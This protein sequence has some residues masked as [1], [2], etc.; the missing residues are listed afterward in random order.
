MQLLFLVNKLRKTIKKNL[1][2]IKE[3]KDS[4]STYKVLCHIDVNYC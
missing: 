3:Q 1:T 2:Y 4:G